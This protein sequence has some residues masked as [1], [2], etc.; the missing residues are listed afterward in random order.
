MYA[1]PELAASAVAKLRQWGFASDVINLVTAASKP[2][3]GAPASAASDDP[4]QS[5]IMAGYVLK[6]HAKV[7]AALIRSKGAALVSMHPPFG[8]GRIAEDLLEQVPTIPTGVDLKDPDVHLWD[9]AAPF[10]SAWRLPVSVKATAPFSAF[11]VLPVLT[12]RGRTL[13]EAA[14]VPELSG[15]SFYLFGAPSLSRS[16]APLSSLFKLPTL[17]G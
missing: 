7:Y 1:T 15:S 8:T 6:A 11:W 4:V 10:S 3:Q 12:R 2:G 16:A 13:C 9:E 14:G 5:T 17:V